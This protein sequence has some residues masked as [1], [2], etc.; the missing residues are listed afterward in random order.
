MNK[1]ILALIFSFISSNTLCIASQPNYKFVVKILSG[2]C[3]YQNSQMAGS[4]TIFNFNGSTY[5]L[6]SEHVVYHSAATNFCHRI[7]NS[8]ISEQKAE[9]LFADWGLGIALL[10]LPIPISADFLNYPND[11]QSATS[12]LVTIAGSPFSEPQTIVATAGHVIN[13]QSQRLLTPLIKYALE[14]DGAH[15]EFGMS[16]GAILEESGANFKYLGLLTHQVLSMVPG[17]PTRATDWDQSSKFQ[18]QLLGISSSDITKILN[19]Y[20][21]NPSAFRVSAYRSPLGQINRTNDII[22]NGL[23]FKPS[24]QKTNPAIPSSPTPIGGVDPVGIGGIDLPGDIFT[25]LSLELFSGKEEFKT[26]WFFSAATLES[27]TKIKNLLLI[28][29]KLELPYLLFQQNQASNE[30][31]A[32]MLGAKKVKSIDE[33]FKLLSDTRLSIVIRNLTNIN[34]Q[35]L[36]DLGKLNL[37]YLKAFPLDQIQIQN[38]V[39]F[40]AA[41]TLSLMAMEDN[42]SLV[43]CNYLIR[44]SSR[45]QE[46]DQFWGELLDYDFDVATKV[47]QNVKTFAKFCK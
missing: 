9:L 38:R 19:N 46:V 2:P 5:V 8:F 39:F 44:L 32:I 33:Y 6:T 20:F 17:A 12:N 23:I 37:E 35:K 10:K 3:G 22:S 43:N 4:G 47:L 1:L 26:A 11:F 31:D 14:I 27:I 34:N 16:G 42:L 7:T 21:N 18:N 28:N 45:D 24:L 13:N 29:Q 36:Q 41:Q 25:S 30:P 15:G 40:T